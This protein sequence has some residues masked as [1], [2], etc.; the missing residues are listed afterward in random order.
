ML[1]W[2]RQRQ[3]RGFDS[4]CT[5]QVSSQREW[6]EALQK[7]RP[8]SSI[9]WNEAPS[10]QL[11]PEAPGDLFG[12]HYP[13]E[14]MLSVPR[15]VRDS[16]RDAVLMLAAR[17]VPYISDRIVLVYAPMRGAYPI[18]Q[19]VS[20]FLPMLVCH[21]YYPVTSS[22][23]FYPPEWGIRN[24]EGTVPSGR[25]ANVLELQR[26]KP[27]LGAF[28]VMVYVDGII[29]GSTMFEH[30]TD[31]RELNIQRRIPVIAVGLAGYNGTRFAGRRSEI[32]AMKG[33]GVVMDFL[34]EGCDC[35]ITENNKYLL[36]WHYVDYNLGP[37]VIPL[38]DNTLKQYGSPVG[39][40]DMIRGT[41]AGL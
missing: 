24:H 21:V 37:N 19:A 31:M 9:L 32:E 26:L 34:W 13:H 41:V 18:W 8:I 20:R 17:L 30:L 38:L 15:T 11:Q 1:L 29:T 14:R 39:F 4:D 22:F 3:P 23:V 12:R 28:D 33:A 25:S 2:L 7:H 16:Y 40:N 27:I 36:G 6:R 35:L 10:F 5:L